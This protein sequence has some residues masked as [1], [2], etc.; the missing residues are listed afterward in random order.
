MEGSS[1]VALDEGMQYRLVVTWA[2]YLVNNR[3]QIAVYLL[4]SGGSLQCY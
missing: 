2:G 3:T 1:I 4:V